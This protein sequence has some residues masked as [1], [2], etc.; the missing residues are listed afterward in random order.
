MLKAELC[1]FP[2]AAN[3]DT[4]THQQVWRPCN[5]LF[6]SK[7]F[8]MISSSHALSMANKVDTGHFNVSKGIYRE[9]LH[10]PRRNVLSD[11]DCDC[12]SQHMKLKILTDSKLIRLGWMF[13]LILTETCIMWQRLITRSCSLGDTLTRSATFHALTQTTDQ[14]DE[15]GSPR[16]RRITVGESGII[17]LWAKHN[18]YT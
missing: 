2:H 13:S 3:M 15:E 4:F 1:L 7:A 14:Q 11:L 17:I 12:V 6:L 10:I 18:C 9:S 5:E 8:L 16:Q